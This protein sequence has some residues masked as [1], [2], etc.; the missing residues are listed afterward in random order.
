ML[1]GSCKMLVQLTANTT[2][3]QSTIITYLLL[4]QAC[5]FYRCGT[6]CRPSVLLSGGSHPNDTSGVS[7][8]PCTAGLGT[9]LPLSTATTTCRTRCTS[10]GLSTHSWPTL[11]VCW[12]SLNCQ[13]WLCWLSSH[14]LRI[15]VSIRTAQSITTIMVMII[16]HVLLQIET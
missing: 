10:G 7:A 13:H 3:K 5:Y 4:P 11:P 14:R 12:T 1:I 8:S 9:L 6:T 2:M 16:K 15:T